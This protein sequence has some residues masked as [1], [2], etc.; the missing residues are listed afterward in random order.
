MRGEKEESDV[1]VNPKE[2]FD[3][4]IPLSVVGCF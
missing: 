4:R 1:F 2:S 3:P